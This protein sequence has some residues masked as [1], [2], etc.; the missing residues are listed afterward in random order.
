LGEGDESHEGDT[1]KQE[2]IDRFLAFAFD[3]VFDGED[4]LAEY[5]DSPNDEVKKKTKAQNLG[6]GA[7]ECVEIY[8]LA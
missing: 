8:R 2:R 4:F 6:E 7:K 1:G 5:F 3:T